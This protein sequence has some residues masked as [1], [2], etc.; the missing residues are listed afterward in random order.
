M[1]NHSTG[2]R[3]AA[4]ALLAAAALPL[5]PL[6][7]QDAQPATEQPAPEVQQPAPETP[8]PQPEAVTPAPTPEPTPQPEAETAATPPA[9]AARPARRAPA[10][11]AARAAARPAPRAVVRAPA[12]VAAPAPAAEAAP[13]AEPAAGVPGAVE[14][15]PAA[16]SGETD[17][18]PTAPAPVD[19]NEASILPWVIGGLLLA[20]ALAFFLLRRRRR[21]DDDVYE[22]SYHEAPVHHEPVA[23]TPLA[24]APVYEPTPEPVIHHEPAPVFQPEPVRSTIVSTAVPAFTGASA[25]TAPV[26]A[27]AATPPARPEPIAEPVEAIAPV[28]AAAP[29]GRPQIDFS[30]RPV[31]AGV[32]GTDARVEFE[33][34]VDNNGAGAAEDVRVSTWLLASG[35]TEAERA[36]IAPGDHADTP[37][38][39]IPAGETRTMQAAVGLS[40]ADVDGDAVLPV[41]VADARYRLPDG[42]Q[43][44]T[45][46]RFA[47]GVPDGEELAHFAIDNP[48][49]LHEGVVAREL[50]EI[51]RT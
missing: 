22:E 10:R 40:T 6:A 12:A 14:Q 15:L 16:P 1:R 43:G 23:E 33:L 11:P 49:G 27:T 18:V 30:M 42:S 25:F 3:R 21:A 9:A 4:A 44:H 5:T 38:V 51:E 32:Q 46:A 50:G 36:L 29:Q 47:V 2:F 13:A 31:R 17:V 48:S 39:T 34:S 26:I 8:Q 41:V 37:P 28:A 19:Q 20:G 35:A 7:A 24:A 45:T